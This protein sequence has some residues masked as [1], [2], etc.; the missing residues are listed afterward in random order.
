[1]SASVQ[2]ALGTEDTLAGVGADDEA[3]AGSLPLLL[4]SL[5]NS[6]E[7]SPLDGLAAGAGLGDTGPF[8]P[9]PEAP[10]S[11]GV[12][13]TGTLALV[14]TLM[15]GLKSRGPAVLLVDGADDALSMSVRS[16]ASF[17]KPVGDL[18][19]GLVVGLVVNVGGAPLD[20]AAVE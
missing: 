13:T 14:D 5:P 15:N 6:I 2:G 11:N 4:L 17:R 19:G 3:L 9:N 18:D 10:R 20:S 7:N 8:D 16:V 1:M 12:E